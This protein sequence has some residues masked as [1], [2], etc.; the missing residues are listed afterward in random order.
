M[1]RVIVKHVESSKKDLFCNLHP[2]QIGFAKDTKELIYKTVDGDFII[3]EPKDNDP[4]I[5]DK[6]IAIN[7]ISII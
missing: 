2:C 7:Y 3:Y 5:N 6:I 4:V 1:I